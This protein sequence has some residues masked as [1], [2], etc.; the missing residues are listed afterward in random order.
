MA[1][2]NMARLSA[3]PVFLAVYEERRLVKAAERLCVT[4]SAVSHALRD[5]ER[6]IGVKLFERTSEGLQPTAS[7]KQLYA[8]VKPHLVVIEAAERELRSET[9]P[10]QTDFAFAS[11]HTFIK[12]FFVPILERMQKDDEPVKVRFLTRSMAGTVRAVADDEALIGST[13]LP[14][15][16]PERF[17][18]VPLTEIREYFVVSPAYFDALQS[19]RDQPREPWT[20][21]EILQQPLITLPR[22]SVSFA[23]YNRHFRQYGL[24]L[25]P[26][27]EVHQEDLGFDLAGRGLGIFIGFNPALF[28]HP[29]LKIL[30]CHSTL[31]ARE[32]V[33]FC[34]KERA[35]EATRRLMDEMAGEFVAL[36]REIKRGSN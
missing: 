13:M 3:Y 31:P 35:D 10:E 27:Y 22:D 36:L 11:I 19:K 6:S 30:S 17:Y 18:V 7:G 15:E 34:R 16:R 14:L 4:P 8:K 5:F 25:E 29:E 21:E 33:L 26:R 32:L 23:G 20:L 24:H 12:A 2:L 9:A 28:G 1:N